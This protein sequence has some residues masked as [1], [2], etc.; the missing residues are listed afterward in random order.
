MPHP[1]TRN[2]AAPRLV[3]PQYV[4][5]NVL[6][7]ILMPTEK[8]NFR[9]TYCYE[10]FEH[11]R[12]PRPVVE[13]LCR[14]LAGRAPCLDSLTIEWF[15]GEPL[16]ELAIIEEVQGHVCRLG[17]EH[18]GL[19]AKAGMTTNGYFLFR[20]TL[21]RLVDLGVKSYQIS[22]DGPR[23][24]HDARR[25]QGCG[26]GTF[27]R[28]WSN[29]LAAHA[30]DLDFKIRLRIHV[31][32]ENRVEIPALLESLAAE[33]GGDERFEVFLRPVS[34]LGGP[35]D[36]TLPVLGGEETAVVEELRQLAAE[37]GL[38]VHVPGGEKP[39][40]AAAAN[41]FVIR[42]TGEIAKCT[43]AFQ[44]PNNRVGQ[45]HPDGRATLDNGKINGWVRGL[46]SGDAEELRCPMKGFADDRPLARRLTVISA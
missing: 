18:S 23:A 31:D 11:G 39:C 20:E 2:D 17:R 12:M 44:H 14:L 45:L 46:F 15:G 40:Y 35:N 38:T 3:S 19:R 25:K 4:A 10:D 37:V 21:T 6:H 7:L 16:L 24:A 34:R 13:G 5:G 9:C 8:C 27:D 33:I 41:S 22:L 42:S 43:V 26:A 1:A 32:R 29:L 30:S 28:V 36:D